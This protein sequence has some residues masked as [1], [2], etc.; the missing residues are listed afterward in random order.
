MIGSLLF[1]LWVMSLL[2]LRHPVRMLPVLLFEL[3]WKTLWLADYGLPQWLAG[4]RTPQLRLDMIEI[5]TIP[6]MILPIVPWGYFWRHYVKQPA[7]RWR[8]GAAAAPGE[9]VSLLRLTLLRANFLLWAVAG[10]FLV[11]PDIVQ[12]DP[13]VRGMLESMLAGLWVTSFLGLRYP[14]QMLPIFLFEFAWKT[15][16][17]I[18]YGLPPW[19]AGTATPQ[20]RA[21]LLG[22]GTGPL[23][24]AIVIPWTHVWRRY[25]IAPAERWR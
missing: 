8:R 1:G 21:D 15:R 10:C 23:L 4:V 24:F 18:Q 9:D 14:L 16:W 13:H 20:L 17:L 22:I 5:G 2:G 19:L 6:F 11:L 25:V 3:I 7:E 12:P